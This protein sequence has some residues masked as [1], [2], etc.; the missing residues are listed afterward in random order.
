VSRGRTFCCGLSPLTRGNLKVVKRQGE[1]LGP[2]PAHAGEPY[3]AAMKR[4]HVPRTYVKR[5]LRQADCDLKDVKFAF[6]E[7]D[8]VI[9]ILKES[10]GGER[11]KG[12]DAGA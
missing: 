1:G 9:S 12:R 6:L 11:P 3:L 4:N 7:T 10:V 8:G 5:A 2:I